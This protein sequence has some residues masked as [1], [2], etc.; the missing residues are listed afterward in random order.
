MESYRL[1]DLDIILDKEGAD[2]YAKASYPIRYGKLCEIKSKDYVFPFNLAGEIKYIKGV[3]HNWP[4][5]A[6]LY[7]APNFLKVYRLKKLPPTRQ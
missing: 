2:R 4:H 5:P 6:G 3:N 7:R 1:N